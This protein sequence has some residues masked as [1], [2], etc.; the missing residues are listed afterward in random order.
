MAVFTRDRQNKNKTNKQTKIVK[1]ALNSAAFQRT[2]VKINDIKVYIWKWFWCIFKRVDAIILIHNQPEQ[3][4]Q[5]PEFCGKDN[6]LISH[7][8]Y[9]IIATTLCKVLC[10]F[11]NDIKTTTTLW[12]RVTH[13]HT[14]R[15]RNGYFVA[16]FHYFK[17]YNII[18]KFMTKRTAVERRIYN[19]KNK[20]SSN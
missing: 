4:L 5:L 10:S 6:V 9:G 1:I 20:H 16:Y 15:N 18:C 17:Y 12:W 7:V 11:E 3:I 2:E 8:I 13:T 19:I 14:L